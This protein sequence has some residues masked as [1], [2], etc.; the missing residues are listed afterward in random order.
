[1]LI[2]INTPNVKIVLN[3]KRYNVQSLLTAV[4][5]DANTVDPTLLLPLVKSE[6]VN[7]FCSAPNG[8]M[9]IYFYTKYVEVI[10]N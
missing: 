10:E 7:S 8:I 1:M 3:I 6:V 4:S 5:V 2:K 9:N